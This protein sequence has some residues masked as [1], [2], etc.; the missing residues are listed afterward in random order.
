MT[1]FNQYEKKD[2]A[3]QICIDTRRDQHPALKYSVAAA[4]IGVLLVAAFV[5]HPAFETLLIEEGVWRIYLFLSVFPVFLRI[6]VFEGVGELV[7]FH[8]AFVGAEEGFVA[9]H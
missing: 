5:Y 8:L 1:C 3:F 4:Y 6:K 7:E 2:V 9:F